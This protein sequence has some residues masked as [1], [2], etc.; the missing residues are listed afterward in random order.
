MLKT[1]FNSIQTE[2]LYVMIK[3]F[4]VGLLISDRAMGKPVPDQKPF[5]VAGLN[6]EHI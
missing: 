4:P 3:S 6:Q 5:L 1:M 2:I